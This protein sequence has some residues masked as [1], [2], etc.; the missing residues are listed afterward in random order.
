MEKCL[1]RASCQ[2]ISIIWLCFFILTP[3][4]WSRTSE[5]K[6]PFDMPKT[7]WLCA[8]AQ[9]YVVST[10]GLRCLFKYEAFLC[11][12]RRYWT[13]SENSLLMC[14]EVM[15][16]MSSCTDKL[17]VVVRSGPTSYG[18][19]NILVCFALCLPPKRASRRFAWGEI[20]PYTH[21]STDLCSKRSFSF[22]QTLLYVFRLV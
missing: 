13:L 18:G 9:V 20:R 6:K 2:D 1:K 5:E 11:C 12:F 15:F 22:G 7:A 16:F 4:C 17:L 10:W 3:L 14:R 21:P 8:L 19:Q